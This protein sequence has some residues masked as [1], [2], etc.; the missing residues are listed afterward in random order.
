MHYIDVILV[1]IGTAALFAMSYF[2]FHLATLLKPQGEKRNFYSF[3]IPFLWLPSSYWYQ[4]LVDR[5]DKFKMKAW[6]C[7]FISRNIF[8]ITLLSLII[9]NF[10]K[11]VAPTT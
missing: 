2:G 6:N 8:L 10:L 9:F 4:K 5:E 11:Q 7:F 3:L 1:I